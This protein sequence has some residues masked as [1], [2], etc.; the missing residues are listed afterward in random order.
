MIKKISAS[1]VFILSMSVAHADT[2]TASTGAVFT[3]VHGPGSFGQA[4]QDPSGMIWSADQGKR[5]NQP[6][7]PDENGI[8]IE[9]SATD[10]CDQIGGRLPTIGDYKKLMSYFELNKDQ[11]TDQ[12][13]KDIEAL[14][15]GI[16]DGEWWTSSMSRE[17]SWDT[18]YFTIEF[19]CSQI[20]DF[21]REFV[22]P[23]RC[24]AGVSGIQKHFV[25]KSL[26]LENAHW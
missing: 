1:A 23:V 14:F 21:R 11:F 24:V 20:Y 3:Q 19:G 16:Q 9:S 15:P 17:Y 12:G 8:V 7:Q 22:L 6:I 18:A 10:A 4:W 13:A 5:D 2:Y 25:S 26:A